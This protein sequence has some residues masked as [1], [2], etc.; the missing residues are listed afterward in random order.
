MGPPPSIWYSLQTKVEDRVRVQAMSVSVQ[1]LVPS[2]I[3]GE[4]SCQCRVR[5]PAS[6]HNAHEGRRT[7]RVQGCSVR[8]KLGCITNQTS[9][10]GGGGRYLNTQIN[11]RRNKG[12][13]GASPA[14]EPALPVNPKGQLD[15][16]KDGSLE[17]LGP[18]AVSFQFQGRR[19]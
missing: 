14:R 19:A 11:I 12:H 1:D 13:A 16:E 7:D 10:W 15:V 6:S 18:L 4:L 5:R 9:Q 8:N 3:A 2:I 17:K